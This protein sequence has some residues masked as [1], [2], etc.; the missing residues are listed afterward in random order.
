MRVPKIASLPPVSVMT[1]SRPAAVFLKF[2]LPTI[3]MAVVSAVVL[4]PQLLHNFYAAKSLTVNLKL[5]DYT[6]VNA[7]IQPVYNGV[8]NSGQVYT[9]RADRGEEI[10]PN[11][12]ALKNPLLIYNLHSGKV[13]NIAAQTG[14]YHYKEQKIHL[15]NNVRLK[16]SLGYDFTTARAVIDVEKNTIVG[17]DLVT[18]HA[19]TGKIESLGFQVVEKGN[20]IIFGKSKVNY[21]AETM[22]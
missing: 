8:D 6:S 12:Y 19:P 4:W 22:E 5:Q 16:H 15:Q 7:A 20:R 1:R 9:L 14:T 18:G 11:T 10:A 3:A 2:L 17:D 13:V 21:K